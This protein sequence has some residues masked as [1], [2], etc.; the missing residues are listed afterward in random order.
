MTFSTTVHQ[1]V[2]ELWRRSFTHPFITQMA[3]GK[4]P[5]HKFRFYCIQDYRY[6]EVFNH[7]QRQVVDQ[8]RTTFPIP[9]DLFAM[10]DSELE[11]KERE[12][13]FRQMQVSPRE[14]RQTDLA[15]TNYDYLN[16]L[17]Q[18]VRSSP[19]VGLAALLPCPWLY[20]ELA[21][22]WQ[23]QHSPEPMYDRFFQT[24]AAVAASGEKERM[25]TALN[26]VAAGVS[27]DIR[28]QMCQ[29]FM[30]SSFYELHFW[31]MAMDEEE[32]Q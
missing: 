26:T 14:Y 2:A 8:L 28:K 3:S 1:Q 12:Q 17:R 4:L 15:P 22:Y 29:A 32:W 9:S 6:L 16:H 27:E 23:G 11:I 30:R 18:S 5:V 7:L 21:E 20:N 10:D 31:Q 24:Y 25:I 13:Y 19:A